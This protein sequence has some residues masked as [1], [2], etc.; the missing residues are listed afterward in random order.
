M[1]PDMIDAPATDTAAGNVGPIHVCPLDAVD[2]VLRASKAAYLVTLINAKMMIET[3]RWLD[4]ANHLKLA[5]NDIAAPVDGLTTP[6][7]NHA[8]DLLTFLERWRGEGPIVIHCW[9]GISRSSAA[10]LAAL[11]LFN[12]GADLSILTAHL[13]QRAPFAHPNRM[14]VGLVDRE[15]QLDGALIDAVAGMRSSVMECA[16]SPYRL[17][18]HPGR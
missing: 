1:T 7:R 11:A 3:P 6:A 18:L 9:A 16:G 10:A 12:P 13:R 2:D 8:V 15:L 14:L 4:S 5:M 17:D